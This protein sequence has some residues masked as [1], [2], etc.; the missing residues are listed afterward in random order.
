MSII[1]FSLRYVINVYS[2]YIYIYIYMFI[3]CVFSRQLND[4]GE[5]ISTT[6]FTVLCFY[7]K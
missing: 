3:V 2:I 4:C 7:K 5:K 6:A 1:N